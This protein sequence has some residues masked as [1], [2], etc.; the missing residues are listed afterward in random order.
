MR[1]RRVLEVLLSQIW[2]HRACRLGVLH[3]QGQA[4]IQLHGILGTLLPLSVRGNFTEFCQ[5]SEI[6]RSTRTEQRA[7][8]MQTRHDDSLR[9]SMQRDVCQTL[10]FGLKLQSFMIF[11]M[12]VKTCSS[13]LRSLHSRTIHPGGGFA[14]FPHGVLGSAHWQT[15]QSMTGFHNAA[16]GSAIKAC[17]ALQPPV[18]A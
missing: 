5:V 3:C 14:F 17:S 8:V 13:G 18:H 1:T 6:M 4:H 7:G 11:S 2:I 15:F 16:D 12:A 10:K 9:G